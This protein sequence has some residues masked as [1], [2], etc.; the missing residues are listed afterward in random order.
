M[1]AQD[2]ISVLLVD[3]HPVVRE[4]YR[5]L[6][7]KTSDIQI[8]GEAECG[9]KAYSLY[10][11]A[12]PDVVLLDLNMP[13]MGGLETIRRLLI[14]D[15]K[16]RILVFSMHDSQIILQRALEAGATGYLTKSSASSQMVKAVRQ[17]AQ[18]K[19]Y[20]NHNL[21]PKAVES[22]S[23][24]SNPLHKL[25]QREFEIFRNLADGRSVAEI[26]NTLSISPKTAG[27]H[28]TNIMKKLNMRNVAELARLAVRCDVIIP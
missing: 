21:I 4:G 1:K 9:E 11:K 12:S 19:A 24:N 13:G 27:V 15:P 17:V 7:E 3:D 14:K 16:A 5:L 23:D 28:Q 10:E 25:T 2:K 22:F 26:A 18:G 20:L 8:V 6:L